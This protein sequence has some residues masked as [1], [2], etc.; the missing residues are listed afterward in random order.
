MSDEKTF[1]QDEVN[2]IV[3]E[4]LAKEKAKYDT[5]LEE[6]E[7]E[8]TQ[9]EFLLEARETLT[10]KGLPADL[11]DALNTSSNEAFDKSLSIIEEQFKAHAAAS[12]IPKTSPMT[13]SGGDG[14]IN[15]DGTRTISTGSPHTEPFSGGDSGTRAAMGL[16]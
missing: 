13:V 6:K 8:L 12:D 4:R 11:L 9:R 3:Q 1:T 10:A 14:A 16:K 5:A 15:P 7:K 2:K